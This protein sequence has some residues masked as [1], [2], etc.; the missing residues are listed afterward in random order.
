M[1]SSVAA[2]DAPVSS[3]ARGRSIV[4]AVGAPDTV[5]R[6]CRRAL[7]QSRFTLAAL[8]DVAEL[9]EFETSPT[10]VVT[11][12][13]GDGGDADV[14]AVASVH[15]TAP[16]AKVLC[17]ADSV[18]WRAVR[19]LMCVG[20]S[21]FVLLGELH[22]RFAAAVEAAAGGHLVL[23]GQLREALA[24]PM[25]STREKQILALIVMGLSNAQIAK[26]LFVSESTVKG[27]VSS[28][29]R[30]LGVRSR[31]EAAT[32]IL[33]PERGFGAGILAISGNERRRGPRR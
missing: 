25:L 20:A 21:A 23:P 30:R 13:G 18:D 33:D 6:R 5:T 17:L 11:V 3:P 31:K 12:I 15:A 4:A 8:A 1:A 27:H 22:D 28:A 2:R 19:S 16:D 14:A 29:F 32:L 26:Q 7:R 9:A 24:Q 10:V